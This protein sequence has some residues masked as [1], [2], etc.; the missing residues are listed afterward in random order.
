MLFRSGELGIKEGRIISIGDR[1]DAA[2]LD[3]QLSVDQSTIRER[4][5]S[6]DHDVEALVFHDAIRSTI[7]AACMLA[8]IF[9]S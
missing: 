7:D 4:Q 2:F 8:L 6:G 1:D 9:I 3:A 5:L